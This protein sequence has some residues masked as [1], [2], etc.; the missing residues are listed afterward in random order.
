MNKKS[1]LLTLFLS[2]VFTLCAPL[3]ACG[4]DSGIS[5]VDFVNETQTVGL[6]ENYVLPS[7]V[8]FDKNGNDYRVVYEVKDSQG[9]KVTVLNGRFKLNELGTAKY[10]ITCYAEIADGKYST[11]T[12]VLNVVDKAAPTIS[13]GAIPFAFVGEEYTI[14]GVKITDNTLEEITPAYKVFGVDGAEVE[15]QNGKFIPTSKGEY[16]LQ[17]TATDSAG[18]KGEK[19]V[20]IY[21]REPMGAYVLENFNDEY[22]LPVFSVKQAFLTDDDVVYHEIFDPTPDDKTN[23]DERTGV[24]EGNSNLAT[25]AE[26]GAHYYFKFDDTFK[27]IGD[28]EYIYVKAY[29]KSGIAE[30]KPQV[31][32]YSKNEPLGAGEGVKYNVNEW[33]EIRLTKEDICAPDSTFADPN[34]MREGETPLDCFFRKMTG[35]AGY[36]LFYIPNHEYTVNGETQK[37]NA[38]NYTLYVDEIG[39]KPIFNPTTELEESY[40]LGQWITLNPTVV[41]DQEEGEYSIQ[42]NVTSPSGTKVELTDNKF[43]L[44][45]AGDYTVELTY[46]SDKFNGYT[47]Y[48]VNAISTKDIT[49]GEYVG[50]PT[51]GDVITIPNAEIEGGTVTA[52]LSIEGQPVAMQSANTFKANVAGDYVVTYAAEIDGLIYKKSIVIPV[53][54]G[55]YNANEV[56]SFSSKQ[57][58]ADNIALDGFTAQWLANYEGKDGVVQLTS[59]SS[60][61]YFAFKQLQQMNKYNGYE[62]LV[63][64]MFIPETTAT[65]DSFYLGETDA[66]LFGETR[67][68]WV[69]Y[70]FS[71]DTF[72]TIWIK[73]G[74]HAWNKMINMRADGVIYID[75]IFM[76]NDVADLNLQAQVTNL[77]SVGKNI[78]DGNTFSVTLPN[79]APQGASLIVKGPDGNV[80]QNTANILAKYGEY[81][82]EITCEG[83]L[84]KVTQTIAVE[85]TFSFTFV[86]ENKVEGSAVTLKGYEIKKDGADVSA[87]ATVVLN[88]TLAGYNQTIQVTDSKFVAPITGATYQIEYLV[89][90]DGATYTFTDEV[91]IASAYTVAKNEVIS[92]AEPIQIEK[93]QTYDSTIKWVA[94]YQG[95]TGVA[96]FTAKNWGYFGFQTMQEMSAYA[97]TSALVIR[98]Y[99]DADGY[100][101]T[102][103][104]G[105]ENNCQ[106]PVQVGKWVDYYF[107]GDIFTKNWAKNATT[108]D[109]WTMALSVEQA[110]T[111]YID[112]IFVE[113]ITPAKDGEVL[114]FAEKAQLRY[115]VEEN[116]SIEWMESYEGETGVAKMTATTAWGYFGF[117]PMQDISAYADGQYIVVR[118]YIA[119]GYAGSLWF[120]GQKIYEEGTV[121]TGKWADYYFPADI[122]KTNWAESATKYDVWTMALSFGSACEVYIDSIFVVNQ[123]TQVN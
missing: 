104:L 45:E 65:S 5:L 80:V 46:V 41:T 54:R 67:G 31:T 17:V 78:K 38:H 72:R 23:G 110:A 14:S 28:F 84:G 22:G 99:I 86:G 8:A 97:N 33:V 53:Q 12:I 89:T 90:Y 73:E 74:F 10:V 114:T 109:I 63:I 7:G 79:S 13:T 56:N 4:S 92:F 25:S 83:Y 48:V 69:E 47:K 122:F 29:I 49:I 18:N 100:A 40:D 85:G 58:M 101:G 51:Q 95:K 118:M 103:W 55:Q 39:Y 76:M 37:D 16:T 96:K 106:T 21:V 66:C 1:K 44:V 3:A 24:A 9:E 34:E 60:W 116:S 98:M 6:G 11:R 117:K 81:T 87:D 52:S 102:L 123:L 93:T 19:E 27:D 119:D 43:R 71:G 68:E 32:L 42:V 105:G 50:T 115:T 107:P 91:K 62:Y 61:S 59:T 26:Y 120:G 2:A 75:E 121:E 82:V 20:P 15:V 111:I 108:Y 113:T 30:Y 70:A 35:D 94:E 64:R 88:V 112:E 77:T 36:Y 57:E